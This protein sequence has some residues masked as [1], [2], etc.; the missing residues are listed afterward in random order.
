MMHMDTWT[1]HSLKRERESIK[2][3][4]GICPLPTPYHFLLNMYSLILQNLMKKM[5]TLMEEDG[6]KVVGPPKN[7]LCGLRQVRPLGN[8]LYWMGAFGR[9]YMKFVI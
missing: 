5:F 8:I 6:S 7:A 9:C 3:V 2:S 1:P 4:S